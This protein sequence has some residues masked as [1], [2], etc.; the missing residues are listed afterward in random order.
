MSNMTKTELRK[1]AKVELHRHLE[2]ALR[3]STVIELAKSQRVNLPYGD[4]KAL[5]D[6]LLVKSP[7]VNL[8]A[9]LDK[10]WL[11][12]SLLN[13]PEILERIAYEA[14]EDA[15]SEGIQIL[16]LRYSLSFVRKN[17]E[18]L[19]YS[20]IHQSFVKGLA[21]AKRDFPTRVGLIG[22]I[23]RVDP[24]AQQAEI[25]DFM[26]ENADSFVGVD[27]A[28]NETSLDSRV[29][30]PLFEKARRAGLRV[31]IHA[32]ESPGTHRNVVDSIEMLGAERIGH[33]VQIWQHPEIIDFV[34]KKNVTLELCPTSN[35]LTNA[36]TSTAVHPFRR[37]MEAGVRVTINSDDPG[38][39]D[40]DLTHECEIL[41]R[42]HGF[43]AA[44]FA[45]C[46]ETARAATFIKG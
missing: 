39:F 30:I 18:N 12:Q 4:I 40:Y 27:L 22:I 8:K 41:A 45:Q 24:P 2:G 7:M 14:V 21:R 43:T 6:A 32:G 29:L 19:S 1:M 44:E 23:G 16:E 28:D 3:F 9:V 35:W 36:V 5:K 33:G 42:E 34:K 10:F 31:T 46:F 38:I 25:M 26:V 11:T 20:L 37:L 17:H 15:H 13:S